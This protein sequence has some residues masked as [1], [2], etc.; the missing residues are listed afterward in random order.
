MIDE[1]ILVIREPDKE[2]GLRLRQKVFKKGFGEY[3]DTSHFCLE[4]YSKDGKV[5]E[6][7]VI[8]TELLEELA[9]AIKTFAKSKELKKRT[10]VSVKLVE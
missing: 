3:L 8:G 6:S 5:A 1:R 2:L 7:V 9:K 4:A 10:L